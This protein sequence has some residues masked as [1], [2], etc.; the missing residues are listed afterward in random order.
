MSHEFQ[1]HISRINDWPRPGIVTYDIA[2]ILRDPVLFRTLIDAMIEPYKG[3]ESRPS[4][5]IGIESRGFILA[6]AM[7]DRLGVGL[8]MIR[9][10]GK[11][12]PP[13]LSEE[14]SYEYASQVVEIGDGVI[15]PMDRVILVDDI[16]ATGGTMAAAL[17]LVKKTGATILGAAFAIEMTAMAGRSRLTS[18]V[19]AAIAIDE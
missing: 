3:D 16:L 7:A 11:L 6:S 17:K 2:P 10:K 14:Y 13:V 18:P 19:H 1:S 12:P 5:L 4:C 15:G 9:K 8:V